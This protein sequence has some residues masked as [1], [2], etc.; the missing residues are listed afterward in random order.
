[1]VVGGSGDYLELADTVVLMQDYRVLEVSERAQDVVVRHP[2]SRSAT[3]EPEAW[4]V[5]PH[6][7]RLVTLDPSRSARRRG[8][9]RARGTR[10]LRFGDD[11]VDLSALEQLVD[12]SQARSIGVLLQWIGR[13][14][15]AADVSDLVHEAVSIAERRGLYA[16]DP[17]PELAAVRPMELA[18]A[19]NRLRPLQMDE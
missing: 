15:A 8:K 11:T 3:A 7:P 4:E 18:A 12:D 13:H 10:E 2:S 14:A 19:L 5:R 16:L 9:V 17:L 6:R 1:M